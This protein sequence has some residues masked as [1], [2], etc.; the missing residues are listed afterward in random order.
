MM[1]TQRSLVAKERNRTLEGADNVYSLLKASSTRI[2]P[3]EAVIASTMF[4]TAS[5][6]CQVKIVSVLPCT[7]EIIQEHTV[8]SLSP[9]EISPVPLVEL[10]MS[11]L[12]QNA[13]YLQV[14]RTSHS[15]K[16]EY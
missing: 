15:S 3:Q 9:S 10:F 11:C 8:S 5:K 1:P 16:Q 13:A 7:L 14:T 6:K 2:F 12:Q 4:K